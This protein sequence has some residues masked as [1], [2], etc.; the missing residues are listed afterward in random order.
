MI[1]LSRVGIGE[2]RLGLEEMEGD[3]GA[4]RA[5]RRGLDGELALAVGDPAPGLG[6]ARL[7]RQHLDLVGDHEGGIEADAELADERS[8]PSWRRRTAP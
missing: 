7:A 3:V 1:R 6:I 4:A 2:F 5:L 8:H